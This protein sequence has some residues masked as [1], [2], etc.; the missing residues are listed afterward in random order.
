M[1]K[2][3]DGEIWGYASYDVD[4]DDNDKLSYTRYEKSGRVNKYT[5]NGDGGHSHSTW[6]SSDDYDM[7]ED[8]DWYRSESNENTNPSEEEVEE[9]SGCYLTTACM[10]QM[11][12]NFDDK[13]YELEILRWF[14]DKYV[15]KEDKKH[16]YEVAPQIVEKLDKMEY[17]EF[18]YSYIYKNLV[19]KCVDN[20]EQGNYGEVYS[21]YKNSIT[22]FETRLGVSDAEQNTKDEVSM[23]K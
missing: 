6:S 5:D 3:E 19:A 7:G 8:P 10:Q 18:V 11:Q 16:Y 15:S 22:N 4:D 20:I 1:T 21:R 14:R 17:K 12:E 9:R 2:P 23:S 13:C